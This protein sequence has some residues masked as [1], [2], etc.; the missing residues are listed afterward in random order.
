MQEKY[1]FRS[2]E[3]KWQKKWEQMQIDKVG[4]EPNRKKYY[5]LEMFPY[6]SGNLHMG[7]VRNYS[8]GDVVARFKRMQGYNVLHPMGWDAF[9]LP[10]ENAAIKHG[11]HPA[12]WTWDN[13]ANMKRQLKSMGISYDWDR[14]IATCHPDYYRWTQWLFLLLYK[15][16]LAYKKHAAVNW[17]PSCATVL[18]NEQVVGGLCER[19]E[20]EVEKKDLEQWF[21][22]ITDYAERLLQDL[23]KLPGWPEKVKVMQENWI[24]RSEGVEI[25][26]RSEF[27]DEIPVFTTRHDTVYGV[28]YLV[29]APE[30]PLVEKLIAGTRYEDEVRSFV[31]KV[32]QQSVIERTSTELEK[33]G[34]FT[35]AYAINPMNEEKVPILVANY[36]LMEY[37]TGAVMGVPAHDQRDLEFARKYKLPVRVVVQPPGEELDGETMEF[38]YDADGISVNS[39]PFSGLATP[40]AKQKIAD[41]MEA[42]GIGRRKVNYRLRDWL[43]SRQRYWGAPIPIIYCDKCGT[44]PVPEKDLPVMLPENV[45]FK[46]TG[47]SPLK[48]CEEFVHTTCPQCGEPARRETDTMD[49]FVCSS[50]YFLRFTSPHSKEMP[51]DK[52]K[53]D[54]W[55]NVDQ[56]I[57][58]VEHA[59]LHLMYARFFN[60]VLYDQGLVPV[61]EPFQ[62]LLTQ[63]MVLKDGGKMSKS[64]GN[65]VSPEDIIARYGADTARLFILFAAPPDRDLEWSDRGVEGCFRF[66]NRVWRLVYA[67]AGKIK[68]VDPLK[69]GEGLSNRDSELR[70]QVHQTIK[71]VTE[72][73]AQRFNFNTAVSA[74]MEMVNHLYQYKENV[75]EEEQNLALIK[76]AVVNL[77]LLLAPF[78]PHITE[79]LWEAIGQEGSI[80]LQSW[81]TYDEDAL[82]QKQVTVVVQIN[83]K[84]RERLEI[85]VDLPRDEVEKEVLE[86]DKVKRF[87]EGK[88]VQKIIYVPNKLVNIVAR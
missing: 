22:R 31:Q 10:A 86:L 48:Y 85:P 74:I 41:Y 78:A 21:F 69:S 11:I 60:K 9:G 28:T 2:I 25:K 76:E 75:P 14:E 15:N 6:P 13:I 56:Y 52:D 36:V 20:T 37:G 82:V 30:H 1:D 54:Y 84:V 70:R 24:G 66:L 77:L 45:E 51:F 12:K 46:P 23:E 55:M 63:G 64:K 17:C 29:L 58:G 79:E 7:H 83:G 19:C 49:T 73:I 43:I 27:G 40:E 33:E 42:H 65:V 88:E 4:E 18:A 39:G 81:P 72:D 50:W 3:P 26:F 57:G 68:F 47:E 61:E 35:G 34:V 87:L 8:I 5:V 32:R 38:A 71:K 67:Y 44:V 16:G 59:I 62:N 53:V 80:H